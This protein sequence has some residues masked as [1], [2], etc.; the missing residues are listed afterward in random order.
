ML[1]SMFVLICF[2]RI[3]CGRCSGSLW[4]VGEVLC[5]VGRK[6][7]LQNPLTGHV[8]IDSRRVLREESE[9]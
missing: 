9:K 5:W 6:L 8:R 7:C 3:A 4:L 2:S 1:F